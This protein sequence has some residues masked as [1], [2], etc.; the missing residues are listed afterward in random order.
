[1][2]YRNQVFTNEQISIDGDS[3]IECTFERCRLLFSA[4]LP[5]RLESNRFNDC[6]WEF[7]G[8]AQT[9]LAFMAAIYHGGGKELIES[10]F[11]KIRSATYP[12]QTPPGHQR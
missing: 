6:T 4:L 3:F 7:A 8:S 11:Q 5:I 9:T 10:T 2:I 1:M 12:A